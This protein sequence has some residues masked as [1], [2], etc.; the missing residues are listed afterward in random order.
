VDSD[1][2][3]KVDWING[4]CTFP[5]PSNVLKAENEDLIIIQLIN[6]N[7]LPKS[8]YN[9]LITEE[10]EEEI[11]VGIALKVLTLTNDCVGTM[12]SVTKSSEDS[13]IDYKVDGFNFTVESPITYFGNTERGQSGAMVTREGPQGRP[14]IIGM[15]VGKNDKFTKKI[16]YGVAI[17]LTKESFDSLLIHCD[18]VFKPQNNPT[19]PKEILYTV[20]LT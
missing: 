3:I 1:L 11:P 19:F 20:P 12:I 16:T 5:V 13:Q 2:L 9:Y 17:P 6:R 15:H 18:E 8:M 14:Y 10:Q 7:S 4:T